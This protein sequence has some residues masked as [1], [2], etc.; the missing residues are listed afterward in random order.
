MGIRTQLSM[1]QREEEKHGPRACQAE[2]QGSTKTLKKSRPETN[3]TAIFSPQKMLG[4]VVPRGELAESPAPL[5]NPGIRVM[6]KTA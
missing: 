1:V 3:L 2:G 4:I 5:A 6:I